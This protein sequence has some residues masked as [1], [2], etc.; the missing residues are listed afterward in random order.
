MVQ[1]RHIFSCLNGPNMSDKLDYTSVVSGQWL[2]SAVVNSSDWDTD[3]HMQSC[4]GLDKETRKMKKFY[5]SAW[6]LIHDS[7]RGVQKDISAELTQEEDCSNDQGTL[8]HNYSTK[9]TMTWA[10]NCFMGLRNFIPVIWAGWPGGLP[11]ERGRDARS[12]T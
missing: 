4:N 7:L 1:L 3:D 8:F 10:N 2:V 11:F 9:A 6:G 12:L 5:N